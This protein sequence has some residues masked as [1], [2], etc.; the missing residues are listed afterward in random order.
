ML[1]REWKELPPVRPP[2]DSGRG[3]VPLAQREECLLWAELL[4]A[5]GPLP[6]GSGDCFLGLDSLWPD[7]ACWCL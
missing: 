1:L 3:G 4:E 2:W 7:S 5:G 6:V